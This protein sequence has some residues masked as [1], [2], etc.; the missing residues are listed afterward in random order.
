MQVLA[1]MEATRVTGVA[2]NVLEYARLARAGVGGRHIAFT[3]AIIRR[4]RDEVL[5]ADGLV[6]AAADAGLPT[7]ILMERHRYD[8]R[9]LDS[10]R[11]V[12]EACDPTIVET[13]HVKSH[14][15]MAAS[16]MWR[17]CRWLAFHHGY[18]RTDLK[19]RAYNQIDRFSLPRADHVVTTNYRFARLLRGRGVRR[20]RITVL[21]NAVRKSV[22]TPEE[23]ATLRASLG[24]R[25]GERV[26]LSVGRLSREKGHDSIIRAAAQ[27]PSRARLV[28]VGDGPERGALEKLARR[29][30]CADSV[31]FAGMTPRVAP[32]YGIA[33]VF[34]LPSLSE[35]S[36][37]VLLEAMVA[38]VPVVATHVGG[39]PEI[40]VD[41]V[42]ALLV[43]P[44]DPPG[45]ACAATMLL[46]NRPLADRLA[47]RARATVGAQ[48]TPERRAAAL[49]AVYSR[50]VGTYNRG[51]ATTA[52]A[53]VP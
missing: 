39:V 36:P 28:I 53:F 4:T 25:E 14:W 8:L 33:D 11:R 48:Y 16:G 27:W 24:L 43:P 42:N 22:A 35:G 31:V 29:L 15:L 2:R 5:P 10:V 32:F 30:R 47:D 21:H 12:I 40:A 49:A 18:T 7:E 1:L 20:D 34:A 50:V 3:F 46:E 51:R 13:H 23:L 45:L 37:N 38:G 44:G 17:R 6:S 52:P 19:V 26:V 9:M 41:G